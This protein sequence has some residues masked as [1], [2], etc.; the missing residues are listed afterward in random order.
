LVLSVRL[1]R[2]VPGSSCWLAERML[3]AG[4]VCLAFRRSLPNRLLEP[5]GLKP[6]T[7]GWTAR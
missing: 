7:R 4:A 1:H 6:T 5:I 3:V 2:I